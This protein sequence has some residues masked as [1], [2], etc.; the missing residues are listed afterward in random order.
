MTEPVSPETLEQLFAARIAELREAQRAAEAANRAKS[1]F[2]AN[3]SHEIRTPMNGILGLVDLL[4][5][6]PLLSEQRRYA[7]TIRES[8]LAL[9]KLINDVLDFSKIEAGRLEIERTETDIVRLVDEVIAG[10]AS[11]A[12]SKW[13]IL[14][15]HIAPEARTIARFDPT[16]V[17]QVLINLVGNAIKFTEQ[18]SVT[19]VVTKRTT[20]EGLPCL[21]FDV[22]DTGVGVDPDVRDRIWHPF[23]QADLSTTRKYGGSGLG[24]S[25]SKQLIDMMG[26]TIDC[27]SQKG[28]GSTFWFEIPFEVPATVS[29]TSPPKA[30]DD[31]AV[32]RTSLLFP[33][34][35]YHVLV[36]EDNPVNQ[37]V[38]VRMLELCGVDV[39]VAN[40]G[41]EALDKIQSEKYHLVLMDCAMPEMDGFE[42]TRRVR[43]LGPGSATPASVPIVAVTANAMAGDRERCINAGMDDY[44]PKPISRAELADKLKYWIGTDRQ[45]LAQKLL[46]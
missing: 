15:A 39:D 9:L 37:M 42:A 3:M 21:R 30:A 22:M 35:L 16:R 14:E 43:K 8:G 23:L 34:G 13:L 7:E 27:E 32:A 12:R 11:S 36:A 29:I 44:L 19:V 38:V 17:R 2:L 41:V 40:N 18:G 31:P 10:L 24:L 1:E 46:A 4:L 33:V 45:S 20:A 26:G 25:I 5:E 28:R 6:T